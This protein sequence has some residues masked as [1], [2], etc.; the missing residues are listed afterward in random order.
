MSRCESGA[1]AVCRLSE[2]RNR[3][4][5]VWDT[6]VLSSDDWGPTEMAAS[7]IAPPKHSACYL[8]VTVILFETTGGLNG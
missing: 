6:S 8:I 7:S 3:A 4:G 1:S 5:C 2:P